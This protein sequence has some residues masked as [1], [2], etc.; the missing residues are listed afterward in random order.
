MLP[1]ASAA[2]QKLTIMFRPEDVILR[3]VNSSPGENSF[4]GVVEQAI[5]LGG[6][7]QCEVMVNSIKV[8]GD[9]GKS[10]TFEAGQQVT[11]EIP[12]PAVHLRLGETLGAVGN[13]GVLLAQAP[14]SR[15]SS[16]RAWTIRSQSVSTCSRSV[17]R[18]PI[19]ACRV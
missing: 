19:A 6:R 11:V 14:S 3:A 15:R 9:A 13:E 18:L 5:F 12:R 8:R 1:M 2:G 10:E 7:V 4:P 16:S 17:R